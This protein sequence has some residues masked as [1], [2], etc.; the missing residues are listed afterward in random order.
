MILKN[1]CRHFPGNYPCDYNK[2]FGQMC[3]DCIHYEKRGIRILIV[4]LDAVGDVLRTT[5]LLPSLK[6]KYPDSYIVWITRSNAVELFV[7]NTLV[8]EVWAV[9]R[10]ALAR[11]MVEKF[12]IMINPDADKMT[13]A[14]A[15]IAKSEVKYGMVLNE[16][17]VVCPINEYAVEWLEMGAFDQIK[18]SNKKT[19][20]QIIHEICGITYERHKPTIC[21]NRKESEWSKHYLNV[22]GITSEGRVIGLNLGGGGRWKRKTWCM[23]HLLSFSRAVMNMEGLYLLVIGGPVEESLMK[24]ISRQLGHKAAISGTNLSLR[25]LASIVSRCSVIVTGDSLVLHMATALEV[26]VIALFGPT[27]AAEIEL[28]ERGDKLISPEC[29]TCYL[30][31][32]EKSPSC[33]EL[34]T[35][36]IVLKLL[37]RILD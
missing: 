30:T 4:K 17:G 32:C 1:D 26:P 36:D 31:D 29:N 10:D 33:M 37:L 2:R 27:S 11:L 3:L 5:S 24:E 16:K 21:L 34:I 35:P 8:D 14:L 22:K 7:N 28:Y 23:E 20:Q 6:K 13:C 9:E 12:D 25:E 15:A 18:Q 19:Y